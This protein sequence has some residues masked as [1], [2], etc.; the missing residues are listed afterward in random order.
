MKERKLITVLIIIILILMCAIY[1]LMNKVNVSSQKQIIKEM[2]EAEYES[3]ITSLNKSN[4]EY[5]NH[6]EE[7]KKI[8]ARAIT[9]KGVETSEEDTLEIM[10]SNI[11][12]IKS[13]LKEIALAYTA[14]SGYEKTQ[15]ITIDNLSNYSQIVIFTTWGWTTEHGISN[16]ILMSIDE[17]KNA[18]EITSQ[19][20]TNTDSLIKVKYISDTSISLYRGARGGAVVM[21]I[22]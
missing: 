16:P 13:G 11:K 18:G 6:I 8:I 10:A 9:D 22:K 2:N 17:F 4:E 20:S 5:V 12:N 7:S 21:L 19:Y 15:N 1:N 14:V 3:S